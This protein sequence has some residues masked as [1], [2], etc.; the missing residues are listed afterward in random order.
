MSSL[1]SSYCSTTSSM[2]TT[3]DMDDF[4]LDNE[5]NGSS[6]FS[7]CSSSMSSLYSNVDRIRPASACSSV[8]TAESV[9]R[10]LIRQISH[11]NNWP[12]DVNVQWL[13]SERDAPQ[14]VCTVAISYPRVHP[15]E[16]HGGGG[17]EKVQPLCTKKK[18]MHHSFFTYIKYFLNLELHTYTVSPHC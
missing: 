12:I 5:S 11:K 16:G 4:D 10:S 18:K 3:D 17:D 13:I 1:T 8:V 7:V 14:E 2:S 6:R 15:C 9:A